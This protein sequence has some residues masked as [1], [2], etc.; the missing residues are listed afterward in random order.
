MSSKFDMSAYT[1]AGEL[2]T[3]GVAE[4][5]NRVDHLMQLVKVDYHACVNDKERADWV[6]R[7]RKVG[8]ELIATT[9]KRATQ[10]D[11]DRRER[12]LDRSAKLQSA[13]LPGGQHVRDAGGH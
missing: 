2:T 11:W 5:R 3:V 6:A 8:G 7:A 9:C 12:A 1:L 13:L 10:T 4:F